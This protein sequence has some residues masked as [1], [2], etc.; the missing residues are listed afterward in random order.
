[1]K[2]KLLSLAAV[3]VLLSGCNL[4]T[5][6]SFQTDYFGIDV[7]SHGYITGMYNL[8]RESR[9]F[10]PADQPSP[11]LALYDSGLKRYYY[12]QKARYAGG[13]YKL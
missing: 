3:T 6:Q 13:R 2:K 8:T 1:M 12:P 7:D 4:N 11:L 9:N 10:S 5:S